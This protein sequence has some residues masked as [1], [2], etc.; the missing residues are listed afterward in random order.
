MARSPS[1][2]LSP[3]RTAE[4][5]HQTNDHWR[6]VL[7]YNISADNFK[8]LD[9]SFF[10]IVPIE[11]NDTNTKAIKEVG[12]PDSFVVVVRPDNYIG[13]ISSKSDIQELTRFMKEA[14]SLNL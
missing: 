8:Q 3:T 2:R 7:L 11:I 9:K 10:N 1:P 6:T 13:Y 4:R 14:Y 12:F 5:Q